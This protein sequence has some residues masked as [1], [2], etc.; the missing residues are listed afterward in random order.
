MSTFPMLIFRRRLVQDPRRFGRWT[1]VLRKLSTWATPVVA[2]FKELAPYA[3]IE[4]LLPGGSLMA[5]TLWF[6]RRRKRTPAIARSL[7]A[8]MRLDSRS[9]AD[10]R[11]TIEAPQPK[12]W[13]D[14]A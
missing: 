8:R 6:Y 14:G 1:A 5:L 9:V 4:L 2:I 12:D 7:N 13:F 11:I 10:N 3:A